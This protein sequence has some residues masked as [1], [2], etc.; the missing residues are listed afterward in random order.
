MEGSLNTI[1]CDR[2]LGID[3]IKGICI[4]LVVF[5]HT[6]GFPSLPDPAGKVLGGFFLNG[7]FMVSGWLI[8]YGSKKDQPLKTAIFDEFKR[9]I[10]PYV[11]FSIL[12][13]VWHIIICVIFDNTCVSDIYTGWE[14]ILRD[15]FCF[16]SGL[17]IGTL[18][19]LPVLFVSYAVSLVTVRYANKRIVWGICLIFLLFGML[20]QGVNVEPVSFFTKILSEYLNTLYRIIN[21]IAYSLLGF[22]LHSYWTQIRMRFKLVI[23]IAFL[24]SGLIIILSVPEPVVFILCI[25]LFIIL[26]S[27]QE[28]P[29]LIDNLGIICYLGCNSLAIMIVHYIFLYPVEKPFIKG[30]LFFACNLLTTLLVIFLLR[31]NSLV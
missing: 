1:K 9:L 11:S 22:L 16:F 10:V 28:I 30:W 25:C 23:P 5:C 27:L 4:T 21:G 3:L 18:W 20:I 8:F 26:M 2:S 14:V 13:I 31:D 12:A 6:V 17:G 15:V 19:F 24:L 7:F 29:A